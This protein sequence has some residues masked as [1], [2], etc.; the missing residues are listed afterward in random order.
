MDSAIPFSVSVKWSESISST[1][2]VLKRNQV[3]WFTHMPLRFSGAFSLLAYSCSWSQLKGFKTRAQNNLRALQ[4][5][6]M[7]CV[8]EH[9]WIKIGR[10]QCLLVFGSDLQPFWIRTRWELMQL[11]LSFI[12]SSLVLMHQQRANNA[13]AASSDRVSIATLCCISYG[14]PKKKLEFL[15]VGMNTIHC[16]TWGGL[17]VMS[18]SRTWCH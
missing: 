8:F 18:H 9:L 3:V 15:P 14:R 12:L 2:T 6:H 16:D 10:L 13:L 11:L 17:E 5:P 1:K 4:N 7:S